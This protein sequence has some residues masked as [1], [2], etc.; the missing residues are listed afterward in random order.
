M[1]VLALPPL[2]LPQKGQSPLPGR[3]APAVRMAPPR[4]CRRQQARPAVP[5]PCRHGRRRAAQPGVGATDSRARESGLLWGDTMRGLDAGGVAANAAIS[6]GG[7]N[8][9]CSVFFSICIYHTHMYYI[10]YIIYIY[11]YI[12]IY[13]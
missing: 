3:A 1:G 2:P 8:Y 12:Y 9:L 13:G 10:L 11:I 5:R 6:A 4:P 7:T